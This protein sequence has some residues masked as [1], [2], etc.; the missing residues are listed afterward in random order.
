MEICQEYASLNRKYI[1]KTILD[2]IFGINSYTLVNIK[3]MDFEK[4]QKANISKSIPYFETIHNYIDFKDS[5]IRKGAIRANKDELVIIPMNMADGS[6]ICIGKG[7]ED[8]NN[9][10]PHGAGRIMSRG[11]AKESI[12]INDYISSMKGIYTTSVNQSTIDESPMV[13][14]PMNE[15][16][17]NIKDTVNVRKR[18]KPIYNFKASE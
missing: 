16:I 15:I 8:W 3:E 2:N 10:A 12:D 9:S 5:I 13:Y 18:I 6:L 14:K 4:A 11:K 7:N 17:N 1:A